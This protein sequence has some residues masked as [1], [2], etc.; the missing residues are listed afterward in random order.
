MLITDPSDRGMWPQFL[1]VISRYFPDPEREYHLDPDNPEDQDE[2]EKL[3]VHIDAIK[4]V[5]RTDLEKIGLRNFLPTS[6]G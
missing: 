3:R 5:W 1:K 2:L 6:S 4:P